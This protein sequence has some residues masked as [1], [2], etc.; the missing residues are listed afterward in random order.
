MLVIFRI[1]RGTK[2]GDP[3]SLNPPLKLWNFKKTS[4]EQARFKEPHP[5]APKTI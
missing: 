2:F 1:L 5:R 3:P 4:D